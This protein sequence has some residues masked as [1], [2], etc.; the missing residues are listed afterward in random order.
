MA[1]RAFVL[2]AFL[3]AAG[4]QDAGSQNATAQS[5][6]ATRTAGGHLDLS[7][8]YDLATLTPLQRPARF[9]DQLYLT[10][11]DAAAIEEEEHQRNLNP[12]N[13]GGGGDR[14]APPVGGDGSTG[15]EGNVGGYNRFWTDRG[16]QVFDIDGKFRTSIVFDPANGRLP[17][18]TP[19][20]RQ[21]AARRRSSQQPNTGEATWLGADGPGPY[22]D[23]E[24]R[25]LAE[26]CLLGF[27]STAGPPMLPVLYNN[28]KRIIQTEHTVMLLV[29]MVHDARI[30][31]LDS[32][33]APPEARFWLGDSIGWW[34]GDTLVVDT[35]NF[36]DQPSLFSASENLHVVERFTRI[37]ADKL[38][39]R[40]TVEDHTVWTAP[41]SGEYAWPA[42]ADRV[43]EY[44]CHEGNYALGAILRGA[45]QLEA[46]TGSRSSGR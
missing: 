19:A 41:W 46:A 22:D 9:G 42:T 11:E 43:Y 31:R 14:T 38:L 36:T 16:T 37:A 18:M 17:E 29:E 40:F 21:A 23:P 32:E 5:K 44:A 25:P 13:E 10:R 12:P 39:Y 34:E 33:H 8:T 7:G 15:A 3:A 35:T 28:L 27:G 26:R 2:I 6:A 45:R 20:A 24:S 30:V 1:L 4:S